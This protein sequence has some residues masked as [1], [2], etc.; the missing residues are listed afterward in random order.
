MLKYLGAEDLIYILYGADDYSTHETLGSIK[1]SLGDLET[2]ATNTVRLDG[3]RLTPAALQVNTEAFPFFGDKRLVIIDGLLGRYESK[4]KSPPK[5][6]GKNASGDLE[7]FAAVLHSA[8]PTTIAV[9]LDGE[10]K[11][12]NPLLKALADT[13]EVKE[14]PPLAP[15]KLPEWIKQYTSAAGASISDEAAEGLARLVGPNLWGLSSELNKL[16]LFATGRRIESA[17][18]NT[19]VTASREVGV[20]ELVDAIMSNRS[21]PALKL[22]QG[23]LRDGQAPSYIL[24]MLARQLRL[25]VRAK[26]MLSDGRSEQFIQDKLK[27]YG[28]ALRRTLDQAARFSLPRLNTLY[29]LILETDLT[30]KTSRYDEDFAISLLIAEACRGP[31]PEKPTFHFS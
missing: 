1:K 10:L 25:M 6:P 26:D 30:I 13:A 28:F 7:A 2:L 31:G 9:L 15:L 27:M 22:L 23:F 20:F 4:T 3:A 18:L 8:P 19:I 21:A 29:H 24:F 5:N 11:K 17:D 14:F 12:T 16:C